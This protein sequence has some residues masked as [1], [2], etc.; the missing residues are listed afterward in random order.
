MKIVNRP[1]QRISN[2]P[3][4]LAP[5]TMVVVW[6]GSVQFVEKIEAE[7]RLAVRRKPASKWFIWFETMAFG[8]NARIMN[9]RARLYDTKGLYSTME[10][11]EE[12]EGWEL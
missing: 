10:E 6:V 1:L 2:V 11:K 5:E 4:M 8:S 3:R 9:E 12:E 7:A